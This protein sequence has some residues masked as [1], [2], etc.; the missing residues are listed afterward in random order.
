MKSKS[1]NKV[2]AVV[3]ALAMTL[4]LLPTQLFG[5]SVVVKADEEP[6]MASYTADLNA[7]ATSKK[8]NLTADEKVNEYVTL[9]ATSAKAWTY[10]AGFEYTD[11]T[12][13]T[14][15]TDVYQTAGQGTTTY[16]SI[17][18]VIPT[19]MTGTISCGF[20]NTGA[21][22]GD[23]TLSL[24]DEAGNEL[25]SVVSADK[26]EKTLSKDSLAAGKYYIYSSKSLSVF[27]VVVD[28]VSSG[29]T[30][31]APVVSTVNVAQ[32]ATDASKVTISGTGTS[33]GEG[34]KYV[35]VRVDGLGN[36]KELTGADGKATTYSVVDVLDASGTY[37]YKVYGKGTTNSAEVSATT[38]VTYV[39]PLA[40]ASPSAA[41]DDAKVIVSWSAV[42][43]ATSYDVKIYEGETEI[44]SKAQTGLTA[45]TATFEGLT[46]GTTY[47]FVV[48]T[49]RNTTA[50]DNQTVSDKVTATPK[51]P[52]AGVTWLNANLLDVF[53][54][55]SNNYVVNDMWTLV[56]GGSN[57]VV[58]T[59]ET[60][61]SSDGME[62]SKRISTKG[63]GD[64]TKRNAQLTLTKDSYVII[65]ARSSGGSRPLVISDAEGTGVATINLAANTATLAP[66]RAI[67]LEAGTY[68]FYTTGGGGYIYAVKVG[69]GEAPRAPWSDVANPEITS[70]VRNDDGTISVSFE[71]EFGTDGADG[72]YV[73]MYQNGLEVACES[74]SSNDTV[75]FKPSTEGDFD[76]KVVI[77]RAGEADKES[78]V[79]TL[80]GYT[81]PLTVPTITWLDNL[82]DGSVYVDWNNIGADSYE[83]LVKSEAD[84]EYT[85]VEAGFT[86]ANYTLTNLMEGAKYDVKVVA[87]KDGLTSESVESI[88]VG[89]H[90]QQW[91][92]AAFGSATSS[93]MTV[94]GTEYEVKTASG[95]TEV[96][97]V[98]NTDGTVTVAG[99]DNGKI[100]DSEDGF[101]YY[102]T[103]VNPNKEHFKLTATFKVTSTEL[104]PDNQTGYAIY[105]TDIAGVGSKDAK[106]FN[107]VSVGQVKMFQNGYH[108]HGA[109][110]ITGY[111]SY[112][113]SNNAG[114]I[115]NLN[116]LNVIGPQNIED[117]VNVGDTFTYTLEKTDAGYVCSMDGGQSYTFEGATSIMAQEDGSICVGVAVARKVSVEISNIK[118]E[119]TPGGAS[120]SVEEQVTPKL[121]IYS[122]GTSGRTDYEFIASPNVGGWLDVYDTSM[123]LVYAGY[124]EAD[125]VV[126]VPFELTNVGGYNT[127][128]YA[129]APD[130]QIKNLTSYMVIDG[131]ISVLLQQWGEEG[132]TIYVSPNGGSGAAGTLEDPLD[133]QT[134]LNHAQPGQRIV[135]LDGTYYPLKDLVIGRSVNGTAD[136]PIV[137]MALNDNKAIIDGSKMEKSSSLISVVGSYWHLFGIDFTNGLGKGVSVCG[138]YN[139]VELCN[140][141]KVGNSGLQISRYAGEPN[142]QQMWPTGNLVKNCTAHDCCDPGRNDADGF[143]AK[144][145]CGE[146]NKFYGCISH[147]NIDDGWDLYAK[148]TTGS[149]GA[150]TIENCVAYSNGFLSTEDPATTDPKLLGEGNGFK[151]GG[152]N[153]PGAHVLRNCISY[154][155]YAKGVTSNSGP[156][157]QVYLCT[158]YN[159]SLKG[160]SY[161]VSLY[162]KT[163]NPKAWVLSG[164]LSVAEN[165]TTAA[166]L[167]S[168]NGVIYSLRSSS[169]YL[170]DGS[171]STN[172][173][174]VQATSDWF[175]STDITVQ[176]TRFTMD[177][178]TVSDTSVDNYGAINMHGLLEL[179]S[180]APTDTGARLN[181]T[182]EAKSV[183]PSITTTV[184]TKKVVQI[185][186]GIVVDPT[187]P[188]GVKTGDTAPI[189]PLMIATV[190]SA[191][192]C[193]AYLF[194]RKKEDME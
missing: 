66:S 18:V 189:I 143:A 177:D 61:T 55:S 168:S 16:R 24:Y 75:K 26:T 21:T 79:K 28:L 50:T 82:G 64:K 106:Y 80:T 83:I 84:A 4:S 49:N 188:K 128:K 155:N 38:Q 192:I 178:P 114:A 115:R 144:L 174:G 164:M 2:L 6:N 35:V 172:N 90:K 88:T 56:S 126:K 71:A 31:S 193:G 96:S 150:V 74:I 7:L 97:D 19:G 170:F 160:G 190:V 116:N 30:I 154:N 171:K 161:N 182:G 131:L 191:G 103:K 104:G 145:T 15:T 140:M 46:N 89:P 14:V 141:Y 67:S 69:E 112:D 148:S 47:G 36:E 133:L 22:N 62:F 111:L 92:I 59:C 43:E 29:S 8:A 169:N 65:Y 109:R 158:A 156:D 3:M 149:I 165:G 147:N 53:D 72:G 120:G 41:A 181:T 81:L 54:S 102:Y 10:K 153:M 179:K 180:T 32:D 183:K 127:F 166:E 34:S 124:V 162:T 173:Q 100:A 132:E 108:A 1:T 11:K 187:K 70:L 194:R 135:M 137:L 40:K 142:E 186:G 184:S 152:E 93:T 130:P 119:T 157:C 13:T 33:G 175:I 5:G 163:S 138:N 12:G 57:I 17:E 91:Y 101:F 134:A 123:E 76:F 52:E 87:T 78:A 63:S 20:S 176:P 185:I 167:G 42:K 60:L 121:N 77:Y 85:S 44:T 51:A 159:N 118:F 129:F 94:A 73:F 37:S 27:N 117:T 98:T 86:T 151:L 45:T 95:V 48:V 9:K 58:E 68:H 99:C 122:S 39:L 113:P 25:A 125:K 105:A 146:G 139:T 110:L 136:K 23:R 107:S